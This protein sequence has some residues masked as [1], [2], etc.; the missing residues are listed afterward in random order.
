MSSNSSKE[1]AY[2]KIEINDEIIKKMEK[3]FDTMEKD[4]QAFEFLVPVDYIGLNI[5][6][7]PKIITNPMDLGTV[8]KNLLNGDY[9]IFQELMNDIN[10]I[11]KNCRTYNLP[12]SDIVKMANHCDK[13]IKQLIDKQF[14]N[15]QNKIAS[16]K[17]KNE[18]ASLTLAEKTKL[19][20]TVR[21]ISNDGLTQ[22]VKIILKEC[23]KAIEDIDNE[24]LQIKVD[25][26]DKKTLDS[27]NQ[28]LEKNNSS[29]N[30]KPKSSKK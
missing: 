19:V 11:W 4:N 18:N 3:I 14:K 29:S 9:K 25:L 26:L 22:I 28:Y 17:N 13:K 27:I 6:D 15:Y 16:N 7:Y 8:K 12:G 10:L 20:E 23:P 2:Y 1:P 30:E 5:L 24:K 21:E